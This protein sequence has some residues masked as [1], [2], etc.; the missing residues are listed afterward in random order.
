MMAKVAVSDAESCWLFTG[1]KGSKG[2]GNTSS[3]DGRTLKA[4]RVAWEHH[5]GPIPD[6]ICVCHKC[7]VPNCVNPAHL[8]LGTI[9]DNNRDMHRKGRA[10]VGERHG[11]AKLTEAQVLE[12]YRLKDTMNQTSIARKFG[13]TPSNICRM[14]SGEVWSS[15]A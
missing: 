9:S 8:F 13:V 10:A 4:H 2:H 3:N 15:L 12:I 6:G 1:G 5:N 11:Q 14:F 7:D